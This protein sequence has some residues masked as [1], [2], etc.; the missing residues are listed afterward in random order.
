MYP[1]YDELF[2]NCI[3]SISEFNPAEYNNYKP[4]TNGGSY[5]CGKIYMYKTRKNIMINMDFLYYPNWLAC[6]TMNNRGFLAEN[7]TILSDWEISQILLH[8]FINPKKEVRQAIRLSE[9]VIFQR[10]H[11]IGLQLRFGGEKAA[12]QEVYVGVPWGRIPDVVKQ[13]EGF[14]QRKKYSFNE[15][16]IYVAS[17][18]E[19]AVD[20]LRRVF[21][22]ALLVV[23]SPLFSYGHSDKSLNATAPY[24]MIV[25]RVM[26]DFYFMEKCDYVFV[27]WQSSLGRLMCNMKKRTQCV[28]VLN[29]RNTD[30]RNRIK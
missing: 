19:N 4:R 15:T 14:V 20:E 16:L 3:A 26:T 30:K 8:V 22:P 12:T 28:R 7:N 25:N 17:D 24:L 18:S 29:D 27:T 13:V 21:N 6:K 9:K 5:D 23:D 10:K 11:K 2:D 1:Q